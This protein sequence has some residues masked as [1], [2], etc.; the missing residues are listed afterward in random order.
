M[1][2]IILVLSLHAMPR[3]VY[4][5]FSGLNLTAQQRYRLRHQDKKLC[6][7]CPKDAMKGGRFCPTCSFVH[8]K[9]SNRTNER[10]RAA[11]L[12]AASVAASKILDLV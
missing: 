12:A 5:K 6:V 2:F 1:S 8:K 3:L 4:D 10:R 7:C 9:T 11:A